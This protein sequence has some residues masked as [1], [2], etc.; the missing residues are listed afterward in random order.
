M[1]LGK[2]RLLAAMPDEVAPDC[3]AAYRSCLARRASG[4]PIAYI[5][6]SKEFYGRLFQVDPR[7]LIPRPDTEL[8]VEVALSLLPPAGVPPIGGPRR[9][10]CHDAFTGSGC[11]GLTIAAE[12]PDVELSLSDASAEALELARGNSRAILGRE[13][14]IRRGDVLSA[15]RGR[16]DLITANPPYVTSRLADEITMRGEGEPRTALDGGERGLDL[17]PAIAEQAMPLLTDG[18][19]LAVETGEEQGG[20]VSAMLE[21]AGYTDVAVYKD[22]AGHDRV[23]SGVKHAVRR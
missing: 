17:Y 6:G 23:V 5:V 11:V 4:V 12:R 19:A 3:L 16:F 8:L 22:L 20:A 15:A 1:G 7:V 14:D 10:R 18:G 9:L 2:E 13:P 21:S